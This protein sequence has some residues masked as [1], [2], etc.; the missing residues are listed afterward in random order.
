MAWRCSIR[1]HAWSSSVSSVS[2]VV[3]SLAAL[4]KT[5]TELSERVRAA[6]A[7]RRPLRIRGSGSKDFYAYALEGE[8]LEVRSYSGVVEYEPTELVVTARAGTPLAEI[9]RVLAGGGQMLACEPPRFGADATL[10]G[11]VAAGLSGPRRAAAGSVRDFV[12]GVK[13]LDARGE[14]LSFGGQVMKN[15]AGFDLSRLLT[16]SFGTLGVILEASLKVLP[17]PEEE[18]T[19]RFQMAEA[20]AIDTMNRW[21]AQPLPISATCYCDGTLAVRLSGSSLG[22]TAAR[23]KLGGEAVSDGDAF[24]ES[25][26]EQRLAAFQGGTLWR[27]S[28]KST[29]PPLK[30]PGTRVI[31]WNGSL[32]WIATNAAADTVFAAARKAG[33][34][35]TRFRGGTPGSPIMQ[36]D[37]GVLALHRRLKAAL[38]PQGV[39]GPR[40]LH[41][42]F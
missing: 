9:D 24:W 13:M 34:H 37:P 11:C 3:Q 22:V 10:G 31:E 20:D 14:V 40:R 23:Q 7:D 32:R 4:D 5:V 1:D 29:T 17:R 35:A 16:G 27:L 28:I 6:A 15:V 33:G 21:A 12:L 30:L 2:S 19:L 39:F 18:A 25:V 36:L 38:D 41:S 42:D 26:R 8:P